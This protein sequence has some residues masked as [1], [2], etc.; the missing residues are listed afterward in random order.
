MLFA[1]IMAGGSGTRF[2]PKSRRN[3]PKQLL[4][5]HGDS[6]MLQQTVERIAPLVPAERVLIITG[7]DQAEA[8]RA[9]LPQLPTANVIAEPCPRDTAPCVGLAAEIVAAQDPDGTMIVMPA[10]HVIGPIDV[11]LKT[12]E[13]A[14]AVIDADPSAL[15]TFGIKPNRPETG[16][17]YIERGELIETRDGVAVNRVVQFREKPDRETAEKFLASGS[18]AWNSGIFLWRARTILQEIRRHKPLLGVALDRVG[19]AWGTAAG[20]DVLAAEFPKMERTPIDKAVMEKAANVKVLEVTYDWND[21]GDWR[22]LRS[23]L[24]ADEHGN[25]VQGDVIAIDTKDSI[26]ISD[27][28]GLVA[29][30]GL[31]DVVV[32]QSGKATFVAR[33]DHL[34]QLKALVESLDGRGYGA[35]L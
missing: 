8:T 15:V 21:V 5:L 33:R 1:I 20:P 35:Y 14:V 2:W 3:R 29:T 34:D 13:A 22:A 17:G 10:D 16:Y 18:F 24:P 30:L 12:V 27:D 26:L 25:A 11:F 32:V 7:A 9:Q 6:T 19:E 4:N 31:D 28:G 23:L